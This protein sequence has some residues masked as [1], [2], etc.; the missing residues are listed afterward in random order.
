MSASGHMPSAAVTPGTPRRL[1]GRGGSL[2]TSTRFARVRNE[3][4]AMP[5][6]G[7][8][9]A[10]SIAGIGTIASAVLIVATIGLWSTG[11]TIGLGT[12]GLPEPGGLALVGAI[13]LGSGGF[14]LI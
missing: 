13:L 9:T 3:V 7:A 10:G 12:I 6:S 4:C 2:V 11:E 8:A 1:D 5:R 14:A